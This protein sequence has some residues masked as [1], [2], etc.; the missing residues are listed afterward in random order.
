VISKGDVLGYLKEPG[1]YFNTPKTFEEAKAV[2]SH[3]EHTAAF[4][5]ARLD[6]D[7][8]K[9]WTEAAQGGAEEEKDEEPDEAY[10]PKV[11]EVPDN[12]HYNSAKLREI[13]DV[14]KDV[15]EELRKAMWKMLE[16]NVKAFGFDDRLGQHESKIRIR[17]D[18]DQRP[19]SILMYGASPEKR[20][21][22]EQVNKWLVLE[23]IK[24]SQSPW[25][26]PVVIAY[27][28]GKARFCIDYRKLNAVTVSD[29]FPIPQQANIMAA[30]SGSQV[31]LLLD[32]LSGFLQMQVHPDDVKKTAFHTHMGLFNFK[33]MPFRL[34]NGPVIFQ[35]IMQEILS[36]F[37]WLFCLVY[38]DNIVVYSKSH[39]EHLGHLNEV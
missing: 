24:V 10:G 39:E 28:N 29:E 19:I 27:C 12:K 6:A 5:Q 34:R 4:V 22:E 37:L 1:M 33:Q 26:T 35:R 8:A 3:F 31:L 18:P 38:I 9:G 36:P 15:P 2:L 7:K 32:A 20:I 13:L 30:L 25:S 21:I 23:V 17:T 14:S 11:V 16:T